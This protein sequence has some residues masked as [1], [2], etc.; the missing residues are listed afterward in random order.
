MAKKL[1]HAFFPNLRSYRKHPHLIRVFGTVLMQ[2]N[3]WHVNRY[4]VSGAVAAG[5]FCSFIPVPLQMIIAAT[6]AILF[7]VNMPISVLLVWISNP[8]TVTPIFY[9]CYKVGA[10]LLA[11]EPGHFYF[12]FSWQWILDSVNSIWLPLMTG[13]LVVAS[14]S[15]ALGYWAVRLYWRYY[16]VSNWRKRRRAG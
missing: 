5:L 12:E 4:S 10:T 1:I 8:L 9:F 7:K 6:F 14:L 3:L 16:V 2:E 15:A 13:C 11:I